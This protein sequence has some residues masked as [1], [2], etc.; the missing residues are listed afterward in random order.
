MADLEVEV[1]RISYDRG[2]APKDGLPFQGVGSW[3]SFNR[4][5]VS[6]SSSGIAGSEHPVQTVE[7]RTALSPQIE[8]R[9]ESRSARMFAV[10]DM[11]PQGLGNDES[12]DSPDR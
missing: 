1:G 11:S 7:P 9:W 10:C 6:P 8:Q 12:T 3:V 5:R 4:S 2:L